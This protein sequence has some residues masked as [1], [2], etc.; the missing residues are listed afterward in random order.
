MAV[1]VTIAPVNLNNSALTPGLWPVAGTAGYDTGSPGGTFTAWSTTN[2]IQFVNNGLIVLAFANGA[3]AS[4]AE[5]LVGRKAGGGLLPAFAAQSVTIA[6]TTAGWIG[7]FS[8]LD[9][10][11]TDG[12]QYSGSLGGI[13]SGPP[14]GV[15]MTCIDFTVT[16]TLSVRLL[17][18]IPA[19]P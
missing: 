14:S 11:Q 4:V 7:P 9:Y 18:L 16:T 12:S 13:I 17:Q 8:P 15:G 1:R 6:A 10:T 19:I 5:I 2:G 3:S